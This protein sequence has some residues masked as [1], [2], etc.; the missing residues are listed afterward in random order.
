ME[1]TPKRQMPNAKVR[2][3]DSRTNHVEDTAFSLRGCEKGRH[4]SRSSLRADRKR[5]VD[6]SDGS[7]CSRPFVAAGRCCKSDDSLSQVHGTKPAAGLAPGQE[8]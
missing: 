2:S 8:S 7:N 1:A 6:L 4:R 5:K 3:I